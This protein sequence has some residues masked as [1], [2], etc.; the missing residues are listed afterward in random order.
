MARTTKSAQAESGVVRLRIGRARRAM[1]VGS[2]ALVG[3]LASS[4]A[5]A[6]GSCAPENASSGTITCSGEWTDGFSLTASGNLTLQFDPDSS[7]SVSS[8]HA[9]RLSTN[10]GYD[11]TLDVTNVDPITST[12]G[13]GIDVQVAGG[14][15][16]IDITTG[17]GSITGQ[18]IGINAIAIDGSIKIGIKGQVT[19]ETEAGIFAR[20]YSGGDINILTSAASKV[21]TNQSDAH[22]IKVESSGN[23]SITHRG[24]ITDGGISVSAMGDINL[25][26]EGNV[27]D[28]TSS[29]NYHSIGV[30]AATNNGNLSVTVGSS[31]TI[32]AED[33]GVFLQ[34][35][36]NGTG[37]FTNA[38]EIKGDYISVRT[39]G[40]FTIDNAGT[41][42]KGQTGGAIAVFSGS[43]TFNNNAGGTLEGPIIANPG[44]T[45]VVN[46]LAGATWDLQTPSTFGG[47]NDQ[48][49]NAGLIKAG[50]S[51]ALNGLETFNNS[52]TVDLT[53][54]NLTGIS[55]FNNSGVLDVQ[56]WRKLG[57]ATLTNNGIINLQ[58]HSINDILTIT[59]D[60]I[61]A[62]G[63]AIKTDVS[64]GSF[65]QINVDGSVT[66]NGGT[67]E[68]K[69]AAGTYAPNTQ[70][71]FLTASQGLT[72]RFDSVTSNLAFLTAGLTYGDDSIVLT[73]ERK[74]TETP[75]GGDTETPSGDPVP[76]QSAAHTPNQ[77]STAV[78]L[79]SLG[80]G[81]PVYDALL[82]QT[83]D[84]A[85]AAFDALSGEIHATT[86]GSSLRSTRVVHDVLL[87]RL[88]AQ[89]GTGNAFG[90]T[91]VVQAAYT[92]DAPGRAVSPV[93]VRFAPAPYL[94]WGQGLGS[95][96]ETQTDG[97]AAT[98]DRS[99]AGFVLGAEAPV[100]GTWRL[101]VAGGYVRTSVEEEARAS[102]GEIDGIFGSLYGSTRFGALSLRFG[103]TLMH[104]SISLDRSIVFPGFSDRAR[105]SYD[106]Y[107]AQAFGEIGYSIDLGAIRLEPFAGLTAIRL[108][109]DGFAE[110]G[111][112]AALIGFAR[113]H[114]LAA[115]TLGLRAEARLS[116]ALPLAVR[117]MVGW[118]HAFGDLDPMSRVAFQ[119]AP[120]AS[121]FV[122]DAPIDR[123]A[124]VTEVGLDWQA[125]DTLKLGVAYS[126]QIGA[127]SQDHAVKGQFE[128]RF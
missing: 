41:I 3:I 22:A 1:L 31:S 88:T 61:F 2:T 70:Y 12:A 20:T 98:V 10:N 120:A 5:W 45:S 32:T 75:D 100:A 65:D 92:A 84:S 36:G 102:A 19:G 33:Y 103:A 43:L 76:L 66:I 37:Q 15:G 17:L 118:R 25:L 95:W 64:A 42:R 24:E 44:T 47:S 108:H 26:L 89:P 35:T 23:A 38:G 119:S 83:V 77:T 115:S 82:L 29:P 114:D 113:D 109:T 46:N 127:Q 123:D 62:N 40:N 126:G 27:T 116:A 90:Q 56:G 91:Q 99:S 96:G 4:P 87:N 79:N 73:L 57:A 55:H 34:M 21:T 16:S 125:S 71:K 85:P 13:R 72:G 9:L 11:L 63:S 121:F 58:N 48:V 86:A 107:T 81:H 101:G 53:N 80:A 67:V 122:A 50:S 124:F 110:E 30:S 128:L 7:I 117:G 93:P 104:E 97:N 111:G 78:A 74:R 59:G 60:V 68:L 69:A 51:S 28:K 54:G 14:S 49:N 39:E 106:G 52:G 8:G 6:A 18:T 112:P 105:A 94:L